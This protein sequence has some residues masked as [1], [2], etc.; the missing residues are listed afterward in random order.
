[1]LIP[2]RFCQS[3]AGNLFEKRSSHAYQVSFT[4]EECDATL[5]EN[6]LEKYLEEQISNRRFMEMQSSEFL[7]EYRNQE[8]EPVV[9]EKIGMLSFIIDQN[10][11]VR[12]C[13]YQENASPPL[14]IQT[15]SK[16]KIDLNLD[17]EDWPLVKEALFVP[18][19]SST[20]LF[21]PY[22]VLE[23]GKTIYNY[24]STSALD[25]NKLSQFFIS[26]AV[27]NDD[28]LNYLYPI[29]QA[30]AQQKGIAEAKKDAIFQNLL[31][32]P[33]DA[34]QNITLKV[35]RKKP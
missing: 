35:T 30:F 26:S 33:N 10:A 22:L 7:L 29:L 27:A 24:A 16:E 28:N 9:L 14:V 31:N 4:L 3:G 12:S 11:T 15:D 5:L 13:R 25:A 1:M 20:F 6:H 17:W 32:Y 2:N 23:D 18:H 19:K 21:I 8:A 34:V